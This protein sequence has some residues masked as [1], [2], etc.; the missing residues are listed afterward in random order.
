MK[1]IVLTILL[2]LVGMASM[3]AALTLD[4]CLSM[5]EANYPAIRQY[6]ILS[7]TRDIDLSDINRGWLPRIGVYAQA[8]V[9]NEVPAFPEALSDIVS[10]MGRDIRGIAKEQYKI[11]ID[12]T[13]TVWDGGASASA[14]RIAEADHR[15]APGRSRYRAVCRARAGAAGVLRYIAA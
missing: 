1:H 8:T 3:R 6:A 5:A 13:Q 11:G 7:R 4:S 10:Q 14:R 15:R 9:Q 2:T 12:L